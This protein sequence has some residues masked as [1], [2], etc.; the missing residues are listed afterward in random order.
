L[1]PA[2]LA[3]LGDDL[4]GQSLGV[5]RF[6]EQGREHDQLRTGGGDLPQLPDA[7]RGRACVWTLAQFPGAAIK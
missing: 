5:F 4:R 6:L 7:I 3:E 2:S 1:P